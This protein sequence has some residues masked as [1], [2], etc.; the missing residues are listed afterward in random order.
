[1]CGRFIGRIRLFLLSG[2]VEGCAACICKHHR[3]GGFHRHCHVGVCSVYRKPG[4]GT[5]DGYPASYFSALYFGKPEPYSIDMVDCIIDK[6]GNQFSWQNN[7]IKFFQ[8]PGHTACSNII[9]F[10]DLMFSGDTILKDTK[11]FIQ[12]RHGGNKDTFKKSIK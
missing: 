2:E 1:M 4:S 5:F 12:K 8:T 9:I 10:N 6:C 7:S 11:P 3:A